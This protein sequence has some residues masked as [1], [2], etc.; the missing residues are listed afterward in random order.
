MSDAAGP[1][2]IRDVPERWPVAAS[3]ELASGSLVRVRTDTVRMPGGQSADREIVEHPG[4]VAVLGL[5]ESG[6]V[7]MIRQ[8]RH[9]VGRLLWEIP[10]GLRD[11]PGEPLLAAAEREL[12]EETGYRAAGWRVLGDFF[13]SPGFS[14]ERIRIFLATGLTRVPAAEREYVQQH[15]EAHLLLAWVPLEQAVAGIL[16]GDLHNG[17]AALG[18]LSA[19]AARQDRFEMLRPTDAPEC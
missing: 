10:A 13:T 5:D 8:Y 11:K 4:A 1:A 15:E 19:S 14:T 17:V 9:P 12:L 16:A 7:L 2:E 3:A 18:I 6:R